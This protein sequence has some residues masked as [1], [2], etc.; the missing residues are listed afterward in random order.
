MRPRACR[1]LAAAPRRRLGRRDP[2]GRAYVARAVRLLR[3]ARDRRAEQRVVVA[4]SGTSS[5]SGRRRPRPRRARGG[6]PASRRLRRTPS[7]PVRANGVPV[8]EGENR[9]RRRLD[10]HDV[11]FRRA[12]PSGRTDEAGIPNRPS[13]A[14]EE[15]RSRSRRPRPAQSSSRPAR[16]RV[17][18]SSPRPFP[19]HTGVRC[20]PRERRARARRRRRSG[21]RSASSRTRPRLAALVVRPGR[22]A[23]DRLRHPLRSLGSTA[24][25]A[26]KAS[27]SG[28]P[29]CD[30][31][32]APTTTMP[33]SWYSIT[34][35]VEWCAATR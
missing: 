14:Q 28:C 19:M 9:V 16:A 29:S 22:R 1:G 12:P 31:V 3:V 6:R 8:R 23:V 35:G 32:F 26:L 17:R 24:S 4:R 34:S 33:V 15:G 30:G 25:A 5:P 11:G 21:G 18:R 7:A 20:R 10:P 27:S 2:G 13:L